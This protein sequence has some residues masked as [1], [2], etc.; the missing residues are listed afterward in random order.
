MGEGQALQEQLLNCL[1]A[2]R[3]GQ[4][5]RTPVPIC[6]GS[7]IKPPSRK[8][9]SGPSSSPARGQMMDEE[10]ALNLEGGLTPRQCLGSPGDVMIARQE[11]K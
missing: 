11:V 10:K 1:E 3:C 7:L 5:P 2:G 4:P 6:T 9:A 8:K